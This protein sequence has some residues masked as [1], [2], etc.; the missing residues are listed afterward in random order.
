[1]KLFSL[2]FFCFSVLFCIVRLSFM[3]RATEYG[4]GLTMVMKFCVSS[5]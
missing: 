3:E 4:Q 5:N 1:M 2:Y